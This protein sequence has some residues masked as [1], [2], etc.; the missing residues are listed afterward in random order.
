MT[1]TFWDEKLETLPVERR[2][3]LRDH[4]LRW[5]IRRSWDGSP[6]YRARLSAAGLDPSSFDGLVDLQRIPVLRPADLPPADGLG[7]AST[8]W[9]VA[10]TDWWRE[11]ETTLSLGPRILTDGDLTHR[12]HLA[13]RA[14]WAAGVRPGA[15]LAA[16]AAMPPGETTVGHA[17]IAP[18][19][20][21]ACGEA[22][23]F[24]WADD[25]FLIETVDPDSEQTVPAGTPG[26][27]VVTDLTREGSP[28]IRF[29]SG[30]ETVLIDEPC[31][32]G[33][34]A[35]RASWVRLLT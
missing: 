19:L 15:A 20:G 17:D 31:P 3:I 13:A 10:P 26:V 18:V 1:R 11:T 4:R 33:R 23:G 34:T 29:W 27:V 14:N 8:E 25:H 32:C 2:Q 5:Q 16:L 28:L 9:T 7:N 30:L 21:Y 22:P 24:H 6:F 12:A 35:M